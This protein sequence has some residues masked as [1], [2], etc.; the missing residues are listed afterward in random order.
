MTSDIKE[1]IRSY[2][3]CQQKERSKKIIKNKL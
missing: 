1:Y 3:E 2:Y